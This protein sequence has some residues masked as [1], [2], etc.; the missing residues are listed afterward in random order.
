MKVASKSSAREKYHAD[1]A[2]SEG[3]AADRTKVDVASFSSEGP[4]RDVR[5]GQMK[6]W[7]SL[8]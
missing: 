3:L 8:Y 7:D 2:G 6:W 4:E 5:W 1:D